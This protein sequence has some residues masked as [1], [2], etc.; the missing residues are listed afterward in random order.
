MGRFRAIIVVGVVT[1]F[2]LMGLS[3]GVR[4]QGGGQGI[5][6]QIQKDKKAS[7]DNIFA[8]LRYVP[9]EII[10][11]FK[12][13]AAVRLASGIEKGVQPEQLKLS[14]TLDKIN[15]KYRVRKIKSIFPD[16]KERNQR[17]E[18]LAH[19]DK[20]SWSRLEERLSRRRRRAD[21]EAAVPDLAGI[22]K[23]ELEPD[24]GLSA[25]EALEAYQ[26]NPEVE[27]AELN[28]IVS[29]NTIPNDPA[30]SHQWSLNNT[31]QL[32]PYSG[33]YNAPPGTIDSDIDAP[34]AWDIYT[35]SPE[36]IIAVVDTGVDYNHRD[37]EHNIWVNEAELSGTV[38]IDDDGN[39]YVDDIYGYD[40]AYNDKNPL[41][42]HGHGT[43]CAGII[44]AE[45]N[46]G[47]DISGICWQGQIMSVKFLNSS[48]Y[49]D[50]VDAV[51]AIYYAV[52]NGA[53]V[54]SNSW[55][56]GNYSETL[57]EAIDYAHSQGVVILAAAGNN[58]SSVP[59][60]PAYYDHV[61]AIAATDSND[62]R[63]PFSNYGDWIDLAA[64]GVDILS[65]RAG[66]TS[67]GIPTSGYTTIASGTSMSCPHVAGACGFLLSVN[68]LLSRDQ[69]YDILLQTADLIAAEISVTDARLN[70]NNA[71]RAA[72][73]SKGTIDLDQDIYSDSSEISIL[74]ADGN[75]GENAGQ[76]VLLISG[77]GDWETVMLTEIIP[78]IGIFRGTIM[79]SGAPV[80]VN[81]GVLQV[82]HGEDITV[83]Y[84]DL[85]DGNSDPVQAID[86]AVIDGI[87]P[88]IFNVQIMAAGPEPVITFE[89]DEPTQT[90]VNCGRSCTEPNDIIRIFTML[91]TSHSFNLKGVLPH[92]DYYFI[93]EAIDVAGN[94]TV[95]DNA[96]LCYA[97]TTT[98]PND[99]YV[100]GG[101]PT[102]QAA[103]NI[104]WDG[105]TV[106]VADG[107]YT[108]EGNRDLD[109][110]GKV[111]TVRSENGPEN[112]I[113]YCQGTASEKHRGFIF[114]NHESST[115]I[116]DGFS[117]TNGYHNN[118]GG[119][120][121]ESS[122]P[123][124]TNCRIINNYAIGDGGGI[125]SRRGKPTITNS[126]IRDNR[127]GYGGGGILCEN[128]NSFI[129]NC[130]IIGNRAI[131]GGGIY[132]AFKK[133]QIHNS[134][135]SNNITEQL[136]GG[137]FCHSSSPIINNCT[138]RANISSNKGAGIYCWY[139]SNP[140]ISNCIISGNRAG[141]K[142][143]GIRCVFSSHPV[144]SNCTI[145]AN[146]ASLG[147]GIHCQAACYPTIINSIMW[148]DSPEE[149]S[150]IESTPWVTYCDVQGG[151]PGL[152]NIDEEPLFAAP[153]Y[154]DPNSTPGNPDDDFWVAGDYHLQ[155]RGWRWDSQAELWIWDEPT[156]RCID[157]GNPGS[158]LGEERLIILPMAPN[159][160]AKNLRINMGA[161]GGTAEA[162]M[163]QP[164]WILRADI[165][166]DGMVNLVDFAHQVQDWHKVISSSPGDL[167]RDGSVDILDLVLLAADYLKSTIW[168]QE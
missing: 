144:I 2:F 90:R 130:T 105:G 3:G 107:M 95:D 150:I 54:I 19:L 18:N 71:L 124:I 120:I 47:L 44:A 64:P 125:R 10:V 127:A 53:E 123:T 29:I 68:P 118:G 1:A 140:T 155:S 88:I 129:N 81:D 94:K 87:D 84:Q 59:Q 104:S 48:G 115:S 137:V 99:I 27:Y 32:Y 16:F 17:L 50:T 145:F 37:L 23:I 11:K 39:G 159:K 14:E 7:R 80:T 134:I 76:A 132:C 22:Y 49:G 156:S 146:S 26:Q 13:A 52:N 122:S 78:P 158:S 167:N 82:S 61:I 63:A 67:M 109:F 83:I 147:G 135:I 112:C 138:I 108:G 148:G 106:R 38:K 74:L 30:F 56:G 72:A 142:G 149:I 20:G 75:L 79:T 116:L 43:H 126:M 152:G 86:T 45:G 91:T 46:N 34:E 57:R 77:E 133:I 9:N 93:I 102:I 151:W 42:D 141:D 164:I 5:K 24:T 40:F 131:Y 98:G 51:S 33:R 62:D 161:Y 73:P 8:D 154:W 162:S 157:A 25:R 136:G 89:T 160:W 139:G 66:G 163:A 92:T 85:D 15:R 36:V 96:G 4:G 117:I 41:D 110:L 166:N 58:N 21:R 55:S 113:I 103:I 128:N 153:G 168:H 97:L 69:V 119:I 101:R 65:L 121:C 28:Y 111:I 165:N 6:S 35:G 31:G 60:Y 12:K 70:L 114:R 143:G 100:P